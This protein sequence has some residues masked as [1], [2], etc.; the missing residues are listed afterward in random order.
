VHYHTIAGV[1]STTSTNFE[2]WLAGDRCD[3]GDGVV[4][5][6]SAHLDNVDSELVV[7]AD[8]FHVH[9]HPLAVQEVRRIL[10]EHYQEYVRQK[11]GRQ[12][13]QLTSDGAQN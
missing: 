4:P 13:L 1:I 6:K 12:E 5:Y 10:L 7:P 3:P 2:R 8:H 11:D 9:H